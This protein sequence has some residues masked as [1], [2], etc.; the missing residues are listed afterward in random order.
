MALEAVKNPTSRSEQ[1]NVVSPMW[2]SDKVDDYECIWWCVILWR[3]SLIPRSATELITFSHRLGIDNMSDEYEEFVAQRAELRKKA[4][5]LCA[6]CDEE[7]RK[8]VEDAAIARAPIVRDERTTFVNRDSTP[9]SKSATS[10]TTATSIRQHL[11]PPN[12]P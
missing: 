12:V 10:L 4:K 7:A 9:D 3:P 11:P 8:R 2:L 1:Q 6:Q 5:E